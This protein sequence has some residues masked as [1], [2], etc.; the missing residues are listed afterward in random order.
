MSWNFFFITAHH[1]ACNCYSKA[2]LLTIKHIS[3]VNDPPFQTPTPS[4][5]DIFI[6]SF[7]S[8]TVNWVGAAEF[9][10][11]N[12]IDIKLLQ[13]K[14][15]CLSH[16]ISN[17]TLRSLFNWNLVSTPI[18]LNC[19]WTTV[20]RMQNYHIKWLHRNSRPCTTIRSKLYLWCLHGI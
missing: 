14:W 5:S 12:P 15:Y 3:V 16:F 6:N 17:P 10:F 11:L 2:K 13:P 9:H 4:P 18:T 20:F 8:N 1:L 19:G 7:S